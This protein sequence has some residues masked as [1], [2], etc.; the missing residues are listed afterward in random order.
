MG[1]IAYDFNRKINFLWAFKKLEPYSERENGV[2]IFCGRQGQG[3]TTSLAEYILTMKK[4]YPDCH[5][6]SNMPFNGIEYES[7]FAEDIYSLKLDNSVQNIIVIDEISSIFTALSSKQ[8]SGSVYQCFCQLRKRGALVIGT[9]QRFDRISTAL[10]EQCNLI[11]DCQ[12]IGRL[13]LNR[14]FNIEDSS[15]G[16]ETLPKM[17]TMYFFFPTQEVY[18]LFD[19]GHIIKSKE[20]AQS[21]S[22]RNKRVC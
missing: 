7:I 8:L 22:R 17:A 1:L 11:V 21:E 16:V 20:V 14:V 5:I 9:A 3:K 2:V 10:R 18:N 13:Q 4:K 12:R 15:E 6:Y 19:S